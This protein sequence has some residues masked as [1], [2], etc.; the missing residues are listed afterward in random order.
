MKEKRKFK[1][2]PLELDSKVMSLTSDEWI[3]CRVVEISKEGIRLHLKEK[4]NFGQSVSLK[5]MLTGRNEPVNADVLIRWSKQLY[6][7]TEFE[8]LCGGEISR[9]AHDVKQLLFDFANHST[10]NKT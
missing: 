8:F 3:A 5:I 7:E 1:R 6:G 2:F 9:I 10:E 4:I